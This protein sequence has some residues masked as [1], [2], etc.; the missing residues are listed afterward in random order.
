MKKILLLLPMLLLLSCSNDETKST[1]LELD[2]KVAAPGDI[3]TDANKTWRIENNTGEA[4]NFKFIILP[5]YVDNA[6][7]FVS[8][9]IPLQVM[10][11][12]YTIYPDNEYYV[13]L[14]PCTEPFTIA[15]AT[16]TSSTPPIGGMLGFEFLDSLFQPGTPNSPRHE[17]GHLYLDNDEQQFWLKYNFLGASDPFLMQYKVAFV[18]FKP[19]SETTYKGLALFT[20]PGQIPNTIPLQQP[21]TPVIPGNIGG[22]TF[23]FCAYGVNAATFTNKKIV[24]MKSGY[25]PNQKFA[26]PNIQGTFQLVNGASEYQLQFS[27]Y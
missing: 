25:L 17:F 1:N 3:C 26:N 21:L 12:N 9:T 18:L 11:Q 24:Y 22:F 2:K 8:G 4:I 20:N 27:H 7:N 16:N 6:N 15:T 19:A 23:Q 13:P 5:A 14:Q 10:E